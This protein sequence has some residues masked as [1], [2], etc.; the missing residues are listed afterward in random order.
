MSNPVAKTTSFTLSKTGLDLLISK[1]T[2]LSS[3]SDKA[4]IV[5]SPAETYMYVYATKGRSP[6]ALKTFILKSEDIFDFCEGLSFEF[7]FPQLKKNI[8]TLSLY[9]KNNLNCKISYVENTRGPEG[10]KVVY[11]E[12]LFLLTKQDKIEVNIQGGISKDVEYLSLK[13][14]NKMTDPNT[15]NWQFDIS[16]ED[17]SNIKKLA[18]IHTSKENTTI[19][20]TIRKGKIL[21]GNIGKWNVEI[22]QIDMEDIPSIPFSK[23]YLN[24]LPDLDIVTFYV[25]DSAFAINTKDTILFF[26]YERTSDND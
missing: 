1:L 26:A 2:S 16:K 10:K 11:N 5:V 22:G 9:R 12:A 14:I 3:L 8:K 7:I 6:V 17:V 13:K 4:R 25:Q 15:G 24:E 18:A 19:E 21:I 23:S 20:V